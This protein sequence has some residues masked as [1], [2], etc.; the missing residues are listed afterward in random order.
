M[1]TPAAK[2]ISF[3]E[4]LELERK[5]EF[6]SEYFDGEVFAM[7]GTSLEHERIAGDFYD[8]LKNALKGRGCEVIKSDVKVRCPTGLGT[9]PDVYALCHEPEFHSGEKDVITNPQ[10]IAEIL[11]PS[12]ESYDRGAK[13]RNYQTIPSLREYVLIAQDQVL[14]E[15]YRRQDDGSWQ[16]TLLN[17]RDQ[18]L[19]LSAFDISISLADIFARLPDTGESE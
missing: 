17:C 9:Y 1:A 13:F 18:S 4:Y 3:D 11:S 16:Y 5:A 10:V 7:A 8:H 15:I 14:V 12:T 6:K 2:R 19:Y